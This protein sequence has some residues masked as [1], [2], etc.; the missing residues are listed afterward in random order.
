MN[1]ESSAKTFCGYALY[2]GL[3]DSIQCQCLTRADN[4]QEL[5]IAWK[6]GDII[7][8]QV[9]RRGKVFY[10]HDEGRED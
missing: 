9:Q 3:F 5:L 4:V 6:R 2:L 8:V 1:Q 7:Q 10:H